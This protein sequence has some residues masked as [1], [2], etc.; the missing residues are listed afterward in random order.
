V[1][2]FIEELIR[3]IGVGALW[4]VTLGRYRSRRDSR[5]SEGAI[6]FGLVVVAAYVVYTASI[7]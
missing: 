7:G 3:G 4:L 1:E 5:L 6:G 2:E